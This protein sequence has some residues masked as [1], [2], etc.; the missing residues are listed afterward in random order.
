MKWKSALHICLRKNE[1]IFDQ[2]IKL[3]RNSFFNVNKEEWEIINTDNYYD[4]SYFIIYNQID[5]K[6]CS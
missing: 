4:K 2:L 1:D 5:Q 3:E 6:R